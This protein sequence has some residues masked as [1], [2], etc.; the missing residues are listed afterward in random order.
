MSERP[1]TA[2]Q[3]RVTLALGQENDD[4]EY[5]DILRIDQEQIERERRGHPFFRSL[6]AYA[7]SSILDPASGAGLCGGSKMARHGQHL[8]FPLRFLVAFFPFT[9]NTEHPTPNT[10]NLSSSASPPRR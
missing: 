3:K 1:R 6:A 7:D 2:N 10:Q 4:C 5:A 8:F 9:P